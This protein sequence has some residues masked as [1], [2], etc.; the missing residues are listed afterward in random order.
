M[1]TKLLIS[2]LIIACIFSIL[3]PTNIIATNGPSDLYS[4]I[5]LFPSEGDPV[6]IH[7]SYGAENDTLDGV[8]YD[9]TSNTLTLTNFTGNYALETNMMGDDFKL[10]I[11]GNN[12]LLAIFAWG[13]YHGGSLNIVGDGTLTVNENKEFDSAIRLFAEESNSVL[14]IANTANV[15]LYAQEEVVHIFSTTESDKSKAIS[16]KNGQDISNNIT[17]ENYAHQE[18][19]SGICFEE[20]YMSNYIVCTKDGKNYGLYEESGEMRITNSPIAYDE[21]SGNYFIDETVSLNPDESWMFYIS[22]N[23]L[24]AVEAAGFTVTEEEVTVTSSFGMDAGYPAYKDASNNKYAVTENWYNDEVTYKIYEITDRTMVLADG[25][26]YNF[27]S[28]S[29]DVQIDDLTESVVEEDD[30]FNYTLDMTELIVEAG[31]AQESEE[32]N[33]NEENGNENGN[34]ENS[35]EVSEIKVEAAED[36]AID[37]AAAAAVKELVTDIA[38]GKDVDG[39]N[40]ELKEKISEALEEGK[41]ISV[42]VKATEVKTEEV[43]EDAEKIEE[44]LAGEGKIAALYEVGVVIKIDGQVAGNVTETGKEIKLVLPVPEGLPAVQEG[45]TRVFTIYMVHNGKAKALK[46]SLENGELLA[47]SS[48]FSTYAVTYEDVKE[49]S[50]PSTGDNIYLYFT[51]FTISVAGIALTSKIMIGKKK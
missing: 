9:K 17:K 35:E 14:T 44:K 34:E 51:L 5:V 10:N 42:E 6:V 16:L 43:K 30:L 45:Y 26:T 20:E 4:Y 8:S 49:T 33:A 3:I 48:E 36:T 11:V 19:I 24:E 1:K 40:D 23:D 27:W 28:L 50:N 46:T 31:S 41:T 2:L 47:N 12:S 25:N 32:P 37:K 29:E 38:E 39:I 13:D 7:N 22:Y 21:V 15:K 18:Y